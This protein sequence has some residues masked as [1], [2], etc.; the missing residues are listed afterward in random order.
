[1]TRRATLTVIL[2]VAMVLSAAPA[3]P[4]A[5]RA[6]VAAAGSQ[7]FSVDQDAAPPFAAVRPGSP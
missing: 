3:Q 1:M 2:A 4:D 7:S 6:T 5:S